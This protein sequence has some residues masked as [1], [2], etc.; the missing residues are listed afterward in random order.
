MASI[1]IFSA[2][3]LPS[4]GGVERFTDS[5]ASELA[6]QGNSVCIVTNNTHDMSSFERLSTGVEI[7]RLPCYSA[8]NGRYPVPKRNR[9]YRE[10]VRNLEDR[11]FDS[12]LVNTRFYMHS[13]FG[14]AFAGRQKLRAVVLDHGSA[15]LTFGNSMLDWCVERYE[16]AITA[17]LKR[18]D[19]AFYGISSKSVEWLEHFGID[20][21]GVIPNSID[22]DSYRGQASGRG[23]RAELGISNNRLL[24]AFTGRLIPEKGIATLIEMMQLLEDEP[25]DLV[26]AGDG[27]LR[28]QIEAAGMA[29]VHL[30]GRLY[31][32]DIAAL[33]KEADLFCLPTR[34]EGFST[35][36]LEAAACGTTSLV[37]DVGGARELMPDESYGFVLPD[38]NPLAF[39]DVAR[40]VLHDEV[41]VNAMGERC[42]R[43]V[44][45]QCSW[46][47]VAGLAMDATCVKT[48]R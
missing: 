28:N 39:A 35:S 32:P 43:R 47:A 17:Y 45:E 24:I 34:S 26:I 20:A 14:V 27:P 48:A 25:V 1:C 9:E 23:F 13:L 36:L 11:K 19:V 8:L 18:K 10:L 15:Y 12:V 37:T 2:L 38:A 22:A 5:L 3:Y 41:D 6:R 42:R 33:L 40:R 30:V 44:E 21:K 31:Q 29:H 4:M 7:I 16:D 46:K